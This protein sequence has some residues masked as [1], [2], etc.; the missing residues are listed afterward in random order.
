LALQAA[1]WLSAYL[2]YIVA[3]LD[4]PKTLEE[5]QQ[6]ALSAKVGY[7]IHHLVEQTSA[8][9]DGFSGIYDRRSG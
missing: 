7:N 8:A 1:E 4:P 2:P 6:D 5:L 3:Y 9:Q